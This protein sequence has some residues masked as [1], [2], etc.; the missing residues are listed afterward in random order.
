MSTI[1]PGR[2]LEDAGDK[3][4]AIKAYRDSHGAY[5]RAVVRNLAK[6]DAVGAAALEPFHPSKMDGPFASLEA[7]CKS[8]ETASSGGS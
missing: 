4:G 3:A 5:P 8:L 7:V 1:Q 6:L 2:V